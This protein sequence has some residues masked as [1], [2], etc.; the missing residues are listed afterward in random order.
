[1]RGVRDLLLTS[2]NCQKPPK[3]ELDTLVEPLSKG[4]E[5]MGNA[6]K[7]ERDWFT[8]LTFVAEAA[9]AVGWVVSVSLM[10][11]TLVALS[12]LDSLNRRHIS[13]I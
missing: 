10:P 3:G 12:H 11:H 8:H 5:A 2:A 9:P 4:I 6:K 1:M 13:G 7:K